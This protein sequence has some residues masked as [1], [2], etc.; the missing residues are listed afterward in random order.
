MLTFVLIGRAEGP[1]YRS[2]NWALL[3]LQDAV[4]GSPV[5]PLCSAI[6]ARAS[7]THMELCGYVC[8]Q[9]FGVAPPA[10]RPVISTGSYRTAETARVCEAW[11]IPRQ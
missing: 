9:S 2:V 3:A 11:A 7:G 4:R 1:P 6:L 8:P 10:R 5:Q